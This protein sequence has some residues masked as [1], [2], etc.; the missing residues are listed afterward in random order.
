VVLPAIRGISAEFGHAAVL[1]ERDRGDDTEGTM[2]CSPILGGHAP[3]VLGSR[4]FRSLADIEF[5]GVSLSQ[6]LEPFAIDG[7]L[8][9]EVVLAPSVLDKAESLID[10][11]RT[12]G[13]SHR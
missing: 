11:N 8:V 10:S 1:V 4:T 9:K 2:I 7:A 13:S 5:D 12:D 3:D 6:I